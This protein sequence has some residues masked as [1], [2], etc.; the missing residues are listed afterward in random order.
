MAK[1]I[2]KTEE[3]G[4]LIFFSIGSGFNPTFEMYYPKGFSRKLM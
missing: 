2:L 1:Y 4:L 3:S